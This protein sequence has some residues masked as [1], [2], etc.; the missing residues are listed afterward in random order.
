[1]LGMLI[2]C[3]GALLDSTWTEPVAALPTPL[4]RLKPANLEALTGSIGALSAVV[5]VC[6]AA[7]QRPGSTS[8]SVALQVLLGSAAL[9]V[10]SPFQSY[11]DLS[12]S[13]AA[14]RRFQRVAQDMSLA[15][16]GEAS[17]A[18]ALANNAYRGS[19]LLV[20]PSCRSP[21]AK[22][23]AAPAQCCQMSRSAASQQA[24]CM[25][26]RQVVCSATCC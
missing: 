16:M 9:R 3:L 4:S 23:C 13:A 25:R 17:L 5:K 22:P 7:R 14:A 24:V 12:S 2:D 1:M 19:A 8:L 18:A 21:P 10:S 11:T 20:R 6:L 26:L 15:L